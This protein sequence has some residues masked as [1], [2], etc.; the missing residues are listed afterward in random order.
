[1]GDGVTDKYKDLIRFMLTPNPQ[2]RPSIAQVLVVLENWE[3][4]T[5]SLSVRIGVMLSLQSGRLNRSKS[6][7]RQSDSPPKTM[8]EISPKTK[9]TNS[10]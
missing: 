5:I 1:M 9:C 2:E 3:L 6:K 10:R 7:E 4:S 8:R